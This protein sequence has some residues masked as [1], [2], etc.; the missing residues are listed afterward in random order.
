MRRNREGSGA[1]GNSLLLSS[2]PSAFIWKWPGLTT[3][4]QDSSG[5]SPTFPA[6]DRDALIPHKACYLS[7]PRFCSVNGETCFTNT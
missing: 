1:P 3:V 4:S 2:G 6:H 5:A 7:P